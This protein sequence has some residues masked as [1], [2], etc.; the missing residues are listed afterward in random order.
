[1]KCLS[2]FVAKIKLK[3]LAS[4]VDQILSYSFANLIQKRYSEMSRVNLFEFVPTIDKILFLKKL[5]EVTLIK[6]LRALCL[7]YCG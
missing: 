6:K 5:L 4:T 2:P 1:M 7:G 3:E